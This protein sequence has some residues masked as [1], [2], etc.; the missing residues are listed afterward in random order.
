MK[1]S[2]LFPALAGIAISTLLGACSSTQTGTTGV[3]SPDQEN[4]GCECCKDKEK[5]ACGSE[6]KKCPKDKSKD[7]TCKKSCAKK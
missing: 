1:K 7:K 4:C 6:D 2:T 5:G 3:N